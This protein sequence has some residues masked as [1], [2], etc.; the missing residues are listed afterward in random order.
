[1]HTEFDMTVPGGAA[2]AWHFLHYQDQ[3]SKDM[4]YGTG[5]CGRIQ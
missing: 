2:L 3:P 5:H 4:C 1:M